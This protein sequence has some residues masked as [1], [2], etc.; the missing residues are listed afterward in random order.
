MPLAISSRRT[1][2]LSVEGPRVQMI[3]VFLMLITSNFLYS[4][5]Y[6]NAAA[7]SAAF[8]RLRHSGPAAAKD[9]NMVVLKT[10]PHYIINAWIQ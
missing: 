6:L 9:A 2:P 5:L 1:S 4:T 3:F 8:G 7:R 10:I